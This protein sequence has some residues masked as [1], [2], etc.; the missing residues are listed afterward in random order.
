[1]ISKLG[2]LKYYIRK[3]VIEELYRKCELKASSRPQFSF[4]KLPKTVNPSK[5]LFYG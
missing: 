4:R 5:K 1:M 2:Q 3:F